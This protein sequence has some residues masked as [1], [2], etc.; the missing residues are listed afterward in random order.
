MII[1][2]YGAN[3]Y[4]S[5]QYLKKLKDKFIK[6]VDQSQ[7][8]IVILQGNKTTPEILYQ[9][10]FSSPFIAKKRLIILKD[11][12]A[13][14]KLDFHDTL[15]EISN[16][17]ENIL[18]VY[19]KNIKSKTSKVFKLL[20]GTVHAQEFNLPNYQGL[21]NFI[22]QEVSL[23]KGS[24]SLQT[25]NYLSSIL[26]NDLWLISNEIDKLLGFNNYTEITKEQIDEIVKP[27]IDEDI[28]RL[29]D[30]IST[31]NKKQ[32]ITLLEEQF[33]SGVKEMYLLSMLVRQFK[34]ML[35]IKD[36]QSNNYNN[37]DE[38]AK[39]IN[40]HPFVAKKTYSQ[41][42]NFEI[43]YLKAIYRY[44]LSLDKSFK[45]SFADPKLLIESFITKI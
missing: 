27:K 4:S 23:R 14:S 19:E 12:L 6:E 3:D 36:L 39:L 16:K 9:E 18:V 22:T 17:G 33:T 10:Y 11:I 29:I 20:K 28:F 26:P 21:T 31:K 43:N 38:I 15:K 35:K 8:N 13:E 45:N 37:T 34:I 24:I 25:A 30:A 41:C 2:I 40:V 42:N 44:L 1:F 32:A 5:A 7:L